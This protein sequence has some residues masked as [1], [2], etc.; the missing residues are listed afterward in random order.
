MLDLLLEPFSY[1]YMLKAMILS[2][3]VGGFVRFCLHI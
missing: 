2:T 3:A 1:D